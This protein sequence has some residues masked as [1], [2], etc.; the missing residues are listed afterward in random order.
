MKIGKCSGNPV[1]RFLFGLTL[2]VLATVSGQSRALAEDV[3]VW[4]YHNF[5]PYIVDA[6]EQRGLSY[7]LA[8]MLT[9]MSDGQYD[10]RVVMLPR[11]RLNQRLSS[12]EPGIVLW[13]NPA[14][15]ADMDRTRFRWTTPILGDTNV[16][17]SPKADAFEYDGPQSLS[18]MTMVGVRGHRY[19]GV[20]GLI[21]D[22]SVERIDVRAERNLV[23][24]IASGRGRVAIVAESAARYFVQELELEDRV[25]F[26]D[27]FHARYQ[28]HVMVQPQL[29]AVHAFV[30]GAVS[31]LK[32]AQ[33][34]VDVVETYGL[35]A[36]V[37]P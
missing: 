20:E 24:F 32:R 17:I 4:V 35:D 23:Q 34:W 13:A 28:R 25:H 33:D 7:D 11:Q 36:D 14:W 22:G 3:S 6:S 16:V 27:M 21:E 10:F 29:E 9:E 37:L 19:Q 5:P 12:G 26:S 30:S 1:A 8:R 18:G 2:C 31:D 15:F